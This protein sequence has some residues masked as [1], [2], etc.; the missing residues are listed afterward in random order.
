MYSIPTTSI[1]ILP[2]LLKALTLYELVVCF[3]SVGLS[4]MTNALKNSSYVSNKLL[5]GVIKISYT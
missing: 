5:E 2:A 1:R 3:H 4:F